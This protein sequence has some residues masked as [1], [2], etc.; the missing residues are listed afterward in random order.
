MCDGTPQAFPQAAPRAAAGARPVYIHNYEEDVYLQQG[1]QDLILTPDSPDA[2]QLV[3]C[4]IETDR[5]TK[6]VNHCSYENGFF[7][8]LVKATYQLSVFEARSG[9]LLG[10]AKVVGD[11][12]NCSSFVWASGPDPN[13]TEPVRA[14]KEPLVPSTE[15]MRD[16]LIPYVL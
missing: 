1:D 3:A 9:K 7:Y 16:L 5:D 15:R 6:V 4:L 2:V 8:D 10:S 13:Q 11:S 12:P 14:Q